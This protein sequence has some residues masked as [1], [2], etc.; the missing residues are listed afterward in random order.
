MAR[1]AQS[2]PV[3]VEMTDGAYQRTCNRC[4]RQWLVPV[5]V[6][7]EHPNA[8][9]IAGQYLSM[10]GGGFE[11]QAKVRAHYQQLA[12]FAKCPQC[13]A[14]SFTQQQ[15]AEPIPAPEPSGAMPTSAR[16]GRSS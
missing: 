6:A 11:P 1:S 5:E 16:P 2:Q 3:E 13:G 7:E 12:G 10:V 8:K 9:D 15:V 14:P 4:Q